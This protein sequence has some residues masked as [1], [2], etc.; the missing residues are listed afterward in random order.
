M[1]TSFKPINTVFSVDSIL[2]I[3]ELINAKILMNNQYGN[4]Y[5]HIPPHLA[6]TIIPYPEKNLEIGKAEVIDY[7][8]QQRPFEV[9]I[10]DLIYEPRSKFFYISLLGE[11]IFEHHENITNLLNKYRD[12][13]IREKDTERLSRGDFDEKLKDNLLNFGYTK[14]F[15]EYKS[16]VTVGNF[17]IE[18]TDVP[19]LENK[20][21][22]ILS[23][24]LNKKIT[25]DNIH[26]VFHTDSKNSQSEMKSLWDKVFYLKD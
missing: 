17:T 13:Y 26:C 19:E 22:N 5:S 10:S 1:T 15:D 20:L 9:H 24:V 25:I 23:P 8:E 7:I 14:V 21:R 6:Y 18:G 16:H 2:D 12:G 3:E 11:K 4:Q